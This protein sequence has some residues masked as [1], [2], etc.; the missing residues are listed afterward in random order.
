MGNRKLPFMAERRDVFVQHHPM[1][2]NVGVGD[3]HCSVRW[4]GA[5]LQKQYG[6]AR[7]FVCMSLDQ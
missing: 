7:S 2:E 3:E 4:T 1:N 5:F 6:A